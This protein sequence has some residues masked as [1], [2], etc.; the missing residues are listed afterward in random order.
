MKIARNMDVLLFQLYLVR[1]YTNIRLEI[2][3]SVFTYSGYFSTLN[4]LAT[5][6]RSMLTLSPLMDK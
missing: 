1:H 5:N 6:N 2:P 4:Q 3:T